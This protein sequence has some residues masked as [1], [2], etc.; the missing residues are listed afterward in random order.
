MARQLV[1][2]HRAND[3]GIALAL[4]SILRV[5]KMRVPH[6]HPQACPPPVQSDCSRY[7]LGY[8]EKQYQQVHNQ[9]DPTPQQSTELLGCL[10]VEDRVFGQEAFLSCGM[11][12]VG[13]W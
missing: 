11:T 6:P 1:R 5:E 4:L 8:S 10:R 2:R 3:I 7:R 13:N 12:R 9:R